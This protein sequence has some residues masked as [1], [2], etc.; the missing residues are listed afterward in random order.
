MQYLVPHRFKLPGAVI[1]PSGFI[2]WVLMQ[3]G[4]WTRVFITVFG[5]DQNAAN[6]PPYH[7]ATVF[8]ALLSFFGFLA[9]L[10]CLAFAKEKVEDE[11]IRKVRLE[12]FQFAA[13]SQIAAIIIGFA[14]MIFAEPG[15]SGMMLFFAGA[16]T[17]FWITYITRFNYIL[18]VKL[19]N[20]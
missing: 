13:L 1:M 14:L 15:E 9:G 3:K 8:V 18:H 20:D 10:Y 16:I 5:P 4:T 2:S 11:M 6:D 17:L 12:S 19:R 7:I